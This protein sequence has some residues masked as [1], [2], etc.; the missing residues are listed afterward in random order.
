MDHSHSRPT[1]LVVDYDIWERKCTTD[2]LA[3]EG[4][5]VIGASNG[6]SG[7]RLAEQNSCDAILVALALPE[8]AGLEFMQ[9]LKT[10]DCTRTTPVIVLGESP[11]GQPLPAAG[12]I[13]K[14]LDALHMFSE[15]SRCLRGTVC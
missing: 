3:A 5:A 10:M 2:M 14:P 1:V 15:L 7:L 13:P 6:A 8:V 4:Y 12:C 11:S 9:R